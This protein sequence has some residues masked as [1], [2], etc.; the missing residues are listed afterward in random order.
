MAAPRAPLLYMPV[1]SG[2]E[3]A[4]ERWLAAVDGED[5]A[6]LQRNF[7]Q[8]T[9]R[10]WW[11]RQGEHRGF[12]VLRH[13]VE[14]LWWAFAA[15]ILP[16][17]VPGFAEIRETLRTTYKVPIPKRLPAGGLDVT[18]AREG[19]LAFARFVKGNLGGQTSIRVDPHWASQDMV[20]QGFARFA[21]PDMIL[22]EGRIAE[23]LGQLCAQLGLDCPPWQP[24]AAPA[25]APPLAEVYD[26]EIEAAARAAYKR[27]YLTFGFSD[28]RAGG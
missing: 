25:A 15:L 11:R 13:P 20:I 10:Q 16:P 21:S 26:A 1:R 22:R 17:G 5:T 12:T 24:P 3:P 9:L 18:A 27:D 8:K 19:F 4:V 2:L 23:G 6:E 14:R 28:W 7:T